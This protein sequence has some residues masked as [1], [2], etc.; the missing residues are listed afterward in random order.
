M[1]PS[2]SY[3][4]MPNESKSNSSSKLIEMQGYEPF[5]NPLDAA[6]YLFL[7]VGIYN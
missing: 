6:I 4:F 2:A 5:G 3:N 7:A 1:T